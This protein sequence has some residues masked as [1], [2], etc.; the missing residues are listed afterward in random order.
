MSKM[1]IEQSYIDIKAGMGDRYIAM[2][3]AFKAILMSLPG[4]ISTRL[5]RNQ[6]KADS[7][8]CCMQW[9]S[10]EH[11]QIFIADPRLKEWAVDF[12]PLVADEKIDYF[13]EA[14]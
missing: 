14:G 9:E 11:K 13:D 1:I 7:F 6:A 5:L 4:A 12:W 8:I 3:P 10:S 2:F